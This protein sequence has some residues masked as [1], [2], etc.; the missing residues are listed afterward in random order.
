MKIIFCWLIIFVK[1]SFSQEY[2]NSNWLLFNTSNSSLSSNRIG[3][4][5]SDENSY[6][7]LTAKDGNNNGALHRLNNNSFHTYDSTNSPLASIE[8]VAID[9]DRKLLVATSSGGLYIYDDLDWQFFN[10]ENSPLPSDTIWKITV[11][12]QNRYLLG[13]EEGLAIYDGNWTF[14]N[15]QN[16][17][18]GITDFNFIEVDSSNNIWIGTD[19]FG[20]YCFD[21][22]NWINKIPGQFSGGT[23][24]PVVGFAVEPSGR[25]WTALNKLGGGVGK[26]GYLADTNWVFFDSTDIGF[27]FKRFSYNGTVVDNKNIKWFGTDHGLLRFD[28]TDWYMINT[29][30]SPVPANWFRVGHVDERNNK[31]FGL[32]EFSVGNSGLI[33]YHEDS[34]AVTSVDQLTMNNPELFSLYQNY[35][36]PFNASTRIKF[37]VNRPQL[38]TLKLYNLL[39]SEITTILNELK[40][41]GL[42]EVE[43]DA[44][45]LPSG[46]YFYTMTSGAFSSAKKLILLK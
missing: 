38:V 2:L 32:S 37:A 13:L 34:V 26:I 8:D 16:A 19:Y 27:E 7:I 40:S 3:K 18:Q 11:D 24:Q 33:F 42:Y 45:S 28:G 39:G 46:I 20:L 35:P 44:S 43:F 23:F 41:P 36:N 31:I 4:I 14:H 22:S 12:K 30:N 9:Q 1:F 21:G 29:S 10:R 17:F 5:I 25:I 6:W 15:S